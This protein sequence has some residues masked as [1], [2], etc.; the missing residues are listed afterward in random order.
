[1]SEPTPLIHLNLLT[2]ALI[3]TGKTTVHLSNISERVESSKPPDLLSVFPESTQ[4]NTYDFHVGAWMGLDNPHMAFE[5][6]KEKNGMG[7]ARLSVPILPGDTDTLKLGIFLRDPTTNM[8]RH[9]AS[10]FITLQQLADSIEN[11]HSLDEAKTM[12]TI[13]D[14]YSSNKALLYFANGGNRH[15]QAQGSTNPTQALCHAEDT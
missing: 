4:S 8:Q 12:I 1:M 5:M 15:S 11:V 2:R 10:K 14:N 3:S 6:L 13:K 9:Y 7:E